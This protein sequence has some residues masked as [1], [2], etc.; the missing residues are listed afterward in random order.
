MA[1]KR[2]RVVDFRGKSSEF[3][4]FENTLDRRFA[5]IFDADSELYL[6]DIWILGAKGNFR[7]QI[8]IVL[9]ALVGLYVNELIQII[10]FFERGSCNLRCDT[11]IG[12]AL[13]YV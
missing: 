9:S 2:A 3:A 8:F 1:F 6:L 5:V 10:P 4:D 13:C 7:S 12:I 11:V